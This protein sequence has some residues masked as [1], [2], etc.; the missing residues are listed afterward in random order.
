MINK[1][2]ACVAGVLLVPIAFLCR[3]NAL[4]IFGNKKGFVDNTRYFFEYSVRRGDARCI[5]LAATDGELAQVREAGFESYLKYSL[6]GIWYAARAGVHFICNGFGDV[7]RPL[8][9]SAKTVNFWHGM[10]IKKIYLDAEIDHS[11]FGSSALLKRLFRWSMEVMGVR[12][13]ALYASSSMEAKLV[14]RALG[15]KFD[16]IHSLGSPRIDRIRSM[17]ASPR[18]KDAQAGR[19]VI[20][21]APTWRECGWHN[22]FAITHELK[23][24]LEEMLQRLNAVLLIKPHPLTP[25]SELECLGLHGIAGVEYS[26]AWGVTDINEIYSECDV[27]V[28]DVSS[29]M[30][31]FAA[32]GGPVVIFMPDVDQYLDRGRGVY[33]YFEGAV[34]GAAIREWGTLLIKLEEA[35]NGRVQSLPAFLE[36]VVQEHT[37][38]GLGACAAIYGHLM[39]SLGIKCVIPAPGVR[40]VG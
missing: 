23:A 1:L 11:R 12:T 18:T 9:L 31:D 27:L 24:E 37:Q 10:P 2:V 30:F 21:Y 7:I 28:T 29:A 39:H 26:C 35:L 34:R 40:G 16:R 22:S 4:W 14:G 17:R 32:L 19:R 36:D 25:V 20:L 33:D 6:R 8:A 15:V 13:Y 38:H 3:Q 5:W